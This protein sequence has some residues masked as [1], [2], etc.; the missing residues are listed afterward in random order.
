MDYPYA[1]TTWL[2][3]SRQKMTKHRLHSTKSRHPDHEKKLAV[4]IEEN[5][6]WVE[7]FRKKKKKGG[8]FK[9]KGKKHAKA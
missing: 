7:D 5:R 4:L 6:Q 3:D 9:K 2:Q 1:K 8:N